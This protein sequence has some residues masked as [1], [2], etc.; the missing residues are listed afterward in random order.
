MNLIPALLATN[1][2]SQQA[3]S[4]FRLIKSYLRPTTSQSWLNQLMIICT[5]KNE[6]DITD[7]WQIVHYFINKNHTRILQFL[8]NDLST[9]YCAYQVGQSGAV[10]VGYNSHRLV[11]LLE[12]YEAVINEKDKKFFFIFT[13]N[14]GTSLRTSKLNRF[15]RSEIF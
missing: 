3:F 11:N 5:Y 15:F 10:S 14:E 6:L 12:K 2:A 9:E 8:E 4:A 1:A 13:K 7:F